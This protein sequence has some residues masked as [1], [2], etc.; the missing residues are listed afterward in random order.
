MKADDKR[1]TE[2]ETLLLPAGWRAC[3]ALARSAGALPQRVGGRS[4][5][6]NYL[7]TTPGAGKLGG[8]LI[9]Q[10]PGPPPGR[11]FPFPGLSYSV[12]TVGLCRGDLRNISTLPSPRSRTP[13]EPTSPSAAGPKLSMHQQEKPRTVCAMCFRRQR[14]REAVEL[15]AGRAPTDTRAR[16][17]GQ[18]WTA[19]QGARGTFPWCHCGPALPALDSLQGHRMRRGLGHLLMPAAFQTARAGG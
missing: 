4:R 11:V 1:P 14:G 15:W 13:G 16:A 18:L 5:C 3:T 17:P 9:K 7:Q 19:G 2:T 8:S 12:T 6:A 10:Q